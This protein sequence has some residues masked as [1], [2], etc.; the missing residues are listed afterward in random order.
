MHSSLY[1]AEYLKKSERRW[2]LSKRSAKLPTIYANGESL[3][4]Q[5][6]DHT[7]KTVSWSSR[8]G[9]Q[10]PSKRSRLYF[11]S[12]FPRWAPTSYLTVSRLTDIS[13]QQLDTWKSKCTE[14]PN[15]RPYI[16]EL[17]GLHHRVFTKDEEQVL[18]DYI[19]LNYVLPGYLFT[20]ATFRQIA[21]QAY[22]EKHQQD[23]T[24]REFECSAGF[25]AGFKARNNFASRRSRLNRRPRVTPEER[26]AWIGK[27]VQL[28][29]DMNDHSRIIN[30]DESCWRV[31]PRAL[32][33][34][35]PIDSQNLHLL[36]NGN[37]KAHLL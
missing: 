33:T 30:A 26:E 1:K 21:I 14:D 24:P 12:H 29:S 18:A 6:P 9:L 17:H 34:W 35:A 3:T 28:L 32:K 10:P 2:I 7:Q 31:Y 4:P 27:L 36:V 37:E 25:I 13:F 15:W 11:H 20:D 5:M 23:E 19:I 16:Y 22:L 8:A